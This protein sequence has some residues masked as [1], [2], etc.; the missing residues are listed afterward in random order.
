MPALITDDILDVVAVT[1][2]WAELPTIIR[3]KYD[4][5]LDRV[6]YYLPFIPGENAKGWQE[7]IYGFKTNSN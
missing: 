4:G 1:G 2:T 3:Q 6:S 7:T 5:L